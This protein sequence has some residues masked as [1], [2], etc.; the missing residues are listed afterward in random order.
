MQNIYSLITDTKIRNAEREYDF[1]CYAITSI[2]IFACTIYCID[3]GYA[4]S[5]LSKYANYLL[6]NFLNLHRN[7]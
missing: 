1:K 5:K 4:I 3:M 2:L 7:L 6:K